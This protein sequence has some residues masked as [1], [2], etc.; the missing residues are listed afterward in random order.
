MIGLGL[1]DLLSL[2]T[3][4]LGIIG[5]LLNVHADIKIR[6]YSFI[7]WTIANAVG[8]VLN[9]MAYLGMVVLTLGFLLFAVLNGI[10]AVIDVI[11]IYNTR[12]IDNAG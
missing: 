4:G 7:I 3:V 8:M 6:N 5:G 12:R 10:Y 1:G 9:Y 2:L 11:G